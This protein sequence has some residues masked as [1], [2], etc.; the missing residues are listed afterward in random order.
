MSRVG[1]W[2]ASTRMRAVTSGSEAVVP[3]ARRSAALCSDCLKSLAD[4]SRLGGLAQEGAGGL[5]CAVVS[6]IERV[7]G[8][9]LEDT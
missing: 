3:M 2:P 1:R 4:G 5:K 9:D 7:R 6:S 8:A